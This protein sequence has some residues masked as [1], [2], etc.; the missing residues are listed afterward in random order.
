M[1]ITSKREREEREKKRKDYY[2][3]RWLAQKIVDKKIGASEEKIEALKEEFPHIFNQKKIKQETERVLKEAEKV[4]VND[5]P[6]EN[7]NH[8]NNLTPSEIIMLGI[9]AKIS[10]TN[11]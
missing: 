5:L 9:H 11:Q 4:G 10:Q 3:R 1:A 8:I 2:E 7:I 6:K